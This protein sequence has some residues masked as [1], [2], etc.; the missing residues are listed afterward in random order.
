[1]AIVIR[2]GRRNSRHFATLVSMYATTAA[3]S[4]TF[5]MYEAAPNAI[6]ENVQL[7]PT[8][9]MPSGKNRFTTSVNRI[10]CLIDCDH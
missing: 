3:R 2:S 8:V 5:G 7:P 6:D 1:M 4:I 10:S 9:V